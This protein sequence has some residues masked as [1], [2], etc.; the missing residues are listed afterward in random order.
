MVTLKVL[1]L[2]MSAVQ[3]GHTETRFL[4]IF[5]F[6]LPAKLPESSVYV[7]KDEAAL[8]ACA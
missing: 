6:L 2:T 1:A 4:H 3:P 5:Y 8:K 7:I